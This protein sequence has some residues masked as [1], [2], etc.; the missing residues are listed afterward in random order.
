MHLGADRILV[1]GVRDETADPAPDP[2][3]PQDFPSFANIAGYMLDTLF[4][5]G[6]YSDLERLTRINQL[7]DSVP[8]AERSGAMEHVRP[9]DTMLV[10]PSRDLREVAYEHRLSMPG[11]IRALLNGVGGKNRSE[12]RLISFLLFEHSYTRA[13]IELGY[14]DGMR[15]ADALLDFVTGK[16]VQRLFAPAWVSEDLSRFDD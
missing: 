14:N 9:I 8:P 12:N 13:L 3:R 10:V 2:A 1:I 7:V 6:L 16:P 11:P 15:V 4:M 5:D